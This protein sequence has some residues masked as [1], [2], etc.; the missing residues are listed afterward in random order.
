MKTVLLI[1][2]GKS[3]WRANTAD[4]DRPLNARGTNDC[5]TMAKI[6][7]QSSKIP[8]MVFYSSA[9]RTEQTCLLLAQHLKIPNK[10]LIKCPEL[11]LCPPEAIYDLM[12]YAPEHLH[13]IAIVAHNPSISLVAAG[14][15]KNHTLSMPTL[16]I[17]KLTFDNEKWEDI[18]ADSCS[19][20]FFFSPK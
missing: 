19:E 13:T 6:I 15:S 1:R 10:Q 12:H 18:D 9:K 2:H 8:Q 3:D 20:Y 5:S 11:Y 4:I 14:L 16:A 7:G 17:V